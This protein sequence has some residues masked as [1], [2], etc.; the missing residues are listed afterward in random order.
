MANGEHVPVLLEE[1]VAALD[2]RPKGTYVDA[3]FGRG[4]HA[5]RILDLLGASGRLVALP[6]GAYRGHASPT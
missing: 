3:T 2:V 1:A 6:V 4:G 5:R